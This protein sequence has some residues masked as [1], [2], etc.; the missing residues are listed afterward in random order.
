MNE[1]DATK[2]SHR[3]GVGAAIVALA[4]LCVS[5]A[6]TAGSATNALHPQITSVSP[7]PFS[8]SH[9]GHKDV[10]TFRVYLPGP[11]HVTFIIQNQNQQTIQ[12]PHTPHGVISKGDHFYHWDG[13]NNHGKVAGNGRYIIHVTTSATTVGYGGSTLYGS[14]TA[15]VTVDD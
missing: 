8:P 13:R 1:H 4:L 5:M 10:T 14:A 15:I 9:K 3:V 7:N 11:E 6:D 12:G 2:R